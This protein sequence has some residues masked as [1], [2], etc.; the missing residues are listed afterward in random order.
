MIPG[1]HYAPCPNCKTDNVTFRS[2]CWR[3]GYALPYILGMDGQP[4]ANPAAHAQTTSRA[5]IERLLDQ[6]VT[7]N[8]AQEKRQHAEALQEAAREEESQQ[9]AEA[10]KQRPWRRWRIQRERRSGA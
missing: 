4:R 8:V 9:T 2:N 6:A 3:C 1:Q 5:D 10:A 7:L